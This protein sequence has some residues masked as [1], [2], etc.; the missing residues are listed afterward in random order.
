MEAKLPYF[1]HVLVLVVTVLFRCQCTTGDI[2]TGTETTSY[3]SSFK[4]QLDSHINDIL[5]F[6]EIKTMLDKYETNLARVKINASERFDDI[7]QKVMV[8]YTHLVQA[9]RTLKAAKETPPTASP[10]TV[11][12][13][14]LRPSSIVPAIHRRRR[15][16]SNIVPGQT[17]KVNESELPEPQL[18]EEPA[19][20]TPSVPKPPP[21]VSGSSTQ[22]PP[23]LPGSNTKPSLLLPGS[24]TKPPSLLPGSNTKPPSL[25]PV[26]NTQLPPLLPGSNTKPPQPGPGNPAPPTQGPSNPSPA[27]GQPAITPGNGGVPGGGPPPPLVSHPLQTCCKTRATGQY[28]GR[29]RETIDESPCGDVQGGTNEKLLDKMEVNTIVN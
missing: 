18:R 12:P 13:P 17:T 11:G 2:L 6:N 24:N 21:L 19:L 9:V 29:Y 28:N 22:P 1:S 15:D 14:N 3:V 8:K 10:S 7:F 25:I 5:A 20:V 26:S 16:S 23:L 4:H 27:S